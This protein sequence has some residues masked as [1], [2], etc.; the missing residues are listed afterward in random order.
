ML[1]IYHNVPGVLEENESDDG[2]EYCRTMLTIPVNGILGDR[3][4]DKQITDNRGDVC[5]LPVILLY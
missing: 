4:V 2:Q 5:F 3:N 1:Y